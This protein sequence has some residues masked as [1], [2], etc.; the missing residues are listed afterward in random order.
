M[1]EPPARIARLDWLDAANQL[2]NRFQTP[3]TA[4]SEGGDF[5]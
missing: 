5:R 2:K 3:E 1:G 4:A